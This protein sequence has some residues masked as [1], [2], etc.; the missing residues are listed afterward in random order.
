MEDV[1]KIDFTD[2]GGEDVHRSQQAQ[3][4]IKRQN[5]VKTVKKSLVP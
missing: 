4:V 2:I 1:S 3:N 5:C